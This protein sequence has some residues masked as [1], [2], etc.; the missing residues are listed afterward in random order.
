MER[1]I[2]SLPV[3]DVTP[4]ELLTALR[5]V[6]EQGH[7]ETARRM[8]SLSGRIFR[9][10]VATSRATSDPSSLLRGA[11]ITPKVTHHSAILDPYA[12]GGL[13]RALDG[14]QGAPLTKLALQLTPHVFVRPG[15]LRRAEWSEFDFDKATWTIP[16]EKMKMRSPHMVPLCLPN[17]PHQDR[18]RH[19]GSISSAFR[20]SRP[21]SI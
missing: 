7:Y 4:A 9:Y 1:D 5:R 19:R 18:R 2:G 3:H 6:E 12:F 8:R 13:L 21:V 14:F 20:N 15:E 10:A 16:A 17:E 11:L